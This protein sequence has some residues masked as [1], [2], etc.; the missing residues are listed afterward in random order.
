MSSR[1]RQ[2]SANA[3]PFHSADAT[4]IVSK[5]TLRDP[6]IQVRS[7]HRRLNSSAAPAIAVWMT[8]HRRTIPVSGLERGL[9]LPRNP[10]FAPGP[11]TEVAT[12][13]V[14]SLKAFKED[15]PPGTMP[16]A[17]LTSV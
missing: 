7:G 4:R 16:Q 3:D 9:T 17:G 8:R 10:F 11:L 13:P 12:L 5:R 15:A 2:L 1:S 6:A 14:V